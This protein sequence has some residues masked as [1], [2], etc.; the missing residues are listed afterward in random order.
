MTF[1]VSKAFTKAFIQMSKQAV[2]N[3]TQKS[4]LQESS[5][6]SKD[7]SDNEKLAGNTTQAL[8][9]K[10]RMTIDE[11]NLIL[12]VKRDTEFEIIKQNYD[13]LFKVNSPPQL[14]KEELEKQ[15]QLKQQQKRSHLNKQSTILNPYSH[16][17]QSKVVRAFERI[18]A[19]NELNN[20]NDGPKEEQQ[21]PKEEQPTEEESQSNNNQ[22]QKP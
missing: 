10:M 22:Q 15:Q 5:N 9:R 4:E 18:Q 21:P 6:N 14:S 7:G 12:N 13:H 19:E 11:A 20:N 3:A 17:L 16:Y 8:T 2:A 1:N